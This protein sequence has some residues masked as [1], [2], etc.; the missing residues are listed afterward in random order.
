VLQRVAVCCSVLQCVLRCVHGVS[1]LLLLYVAVCCRVLQCAAVCCSVLQY[2]AVWQC[3]LQCVLKCVLQCVFV[4]VCVCVCV[5]GCVRVCIELTFD[6]QHIC[7]CVHVCV[8]E[9]ETQR[10]CARMHRH[11]RSE[12]LHQRR[13]ES[14]KI[15]VATEFTTDGTS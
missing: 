13:I 9:T 14:R 11:D 2:V 1:R 8:R 7:V 6:V 5:C 10:V 4:C 12:Y 3:V 15:H